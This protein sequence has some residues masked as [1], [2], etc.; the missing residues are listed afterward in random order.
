MLWTEF[1]STVYHSYPNQITQSKMILDY[2][3]KPRKCFL[4]KC[5]QAI[6]T[7][8]VETLT[9]DK[10]NW[11]GDCAN[12]CLKLGSDSFELH[13]R[14]TLDNFGAAAASPSRHWKHLWPTRNANQSATTPPP[15]SVSAAQLPFSKDRK[16]TCGIS[17]L[18]ENYWCF[19]LWRT[20]LIKS[21]LRRSSTKM[22]QT[23]LLPV[24]LNILIMLHVFSK[25]HDIVCMLH[26]KLVIIKE[27]VMKLSTPHH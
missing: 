20:P 22:Q 24:I 6:L 7:V 14:N 26:Q 4:F 17:P 19:S 1:V 5:F 8:I 18:K 9:I 23:I 12:P 27:G 3:F 15:T 2:Y 21:N 25:R 13:T 10:V 11:I 16:T